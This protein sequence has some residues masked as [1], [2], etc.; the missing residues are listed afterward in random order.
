VNWDARSTFV[1]NVSAAYFQ[2]SLNECWVMFTWYNQATPASRKYKILV[3]NNCERHLTRRNR[4]VVLSS[5]LVFNSFES[6]LE[7]PIVTKSGLLFIC[8]EN[9]SQSFQ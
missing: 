8:T 6:A 3:I 7:D 2:R 4:N 5:L 9:V 1:M